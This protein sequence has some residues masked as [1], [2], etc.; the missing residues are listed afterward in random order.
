MSPSRQEQPARDPQD[1]SE[2][3]ALDKNVLQGNIDLLRKLSTAWLPI[4]GA[5][6]NIC[7]MW[8]RYPS[9]GA[10]L[11]GLRPAADFPKSGSRPQTHH[12]SKLVSP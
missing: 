1:A 4:H 5:K 9:V 7:A 10:S 2:G 8:A 12:D 6:A 11:Q 3:H